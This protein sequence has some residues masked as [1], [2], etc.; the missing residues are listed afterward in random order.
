MDI[1]I[2]HKRIGRLRY[3]QGI[4]CVGVSECIYIYRYLIQAK[5]Q[6][7]NKRLQSLHLNLQ[8]KGETRAMY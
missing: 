1:Y 7:M 5:L 3:K 6:G 2:I 4:V 8:Y